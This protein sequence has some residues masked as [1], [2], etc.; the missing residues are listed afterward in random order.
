[1]SYKTTIKKTGPFFEGDPLKKWDAN[2]QALMAGYAKEGEADV[3]G[4][5]RSGESGRAEVSNGVGR[6]SDYIHGR[7]ASLGGKRW[8][9][10][11]VVS[12]NN[13]GL[14]SKQQG[15]ALMAAASLL[16]ARL[17]A[18]RKTKGRLAR[19]RAANID[20]LKGLR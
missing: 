19:A 10:T 13:H 17:H 4:Q 5:L 12:V 2:V 8:H 9:R 14:L 6:V 15:I 7:V 11:A 20:L 3:V 16:E 18:F 1:M